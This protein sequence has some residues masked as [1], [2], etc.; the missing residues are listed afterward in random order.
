[1]ITS[2]NLLNSIHPAEVSRTQ[3]VIQAGDD[4]VTYAQ[5]HNEGFAHPVTI[6]A[7]TRRTKKG[8]MEVKAYTIQQNISQRQFMGK[9]HQLLKM[10]R[11]RIDD[12]LTHKLNP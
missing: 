4:K 8:S 2:G 11:E 3:V 7:H 1:M 12:Y 5:A 6:P 9:A 10:L